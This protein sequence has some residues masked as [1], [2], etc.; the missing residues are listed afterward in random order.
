MSVARLDFEDQFA[1]T[2]L[3][4]GSVAL[5]PLLPQDASLMYLWLNDI[6]TTGMDIPYRPTDGASLTT[7][8]NTFSVDPTRVLFA[9]REAGKQDT[10]GFLLLSGINSTNRSADL[11]IRIG[12]ETDRNRGT[13]TAAVQLGLGYAWDHLN[14]V[15][16][17]LRVMAANLRAIGAYLAAGF[18]IEGQHKNAAFI[19]GR[20]HDMLT[21]AA[22]NPREVPPG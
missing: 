1:P 12:R 11:G 15:R 9:I 7:W 14:L 3:K 2:L 8:L 13:G 17:Q 20:W 4:C 5:G 10:A 6:E 21:M 16:V 18:V 19:A 22:L